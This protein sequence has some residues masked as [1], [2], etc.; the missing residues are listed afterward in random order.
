MSADPVLADLPVA[1]YTCD[2]DG[3]ITGFNRTAARLW[4]REPAV[5]DPLD[6]YCGSHR[7]YTPAGDPVPHSRC[8]MARA[9]HEGRPFNGMPIRVGRPDGAVLDALAFANP[10]RDPAG[11]LAGGVNVML[12]VT[13]DRR[14]EA[15][16]RKAL[17]DLWEHAQTRT[18]LLVAAVLDLQRAV[19][20][21]HAPPAGLLPVCAHCKAVRAPDQRWR[22]LDEHLRAR[23]GERVTHSICPACLREHFAE[24]LDDPPAG[25]H[26][27]PG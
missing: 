27:P 22:P 17:A 4:G 11:G 24:L 18:A 21:A 2:P 26:T 8:W 23:T 19:A 7:L 1:A 25:D 16:V 6:R 15:A 20:L 9:L 12:D 13:A 10:V 3:L 5:Y 14:A